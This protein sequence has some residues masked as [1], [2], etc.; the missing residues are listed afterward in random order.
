MRSLLM[1]LLAVLASAAIVDR[2]AV[3][4]GRQVITELQ[5]DEELR[6]TAFLNRQSVIRDINSRKAA[7]NRLIEQLLIESEM[8]V[9]RYPLPGEEDVN[10]YFDQIRSG[11]RAAADFSAALERYGLT[12]KV[13]KDHLALQLTT[14]RFI[15][16]RF[17]PEIDVSE[18]EIQSAYER[19]TADL[20]AQH[21]E[22]APSL[23]AS[24]DSIRKALLEER[25]DRAL[26]AW[27]EQRRKR[28]NV[29]YQ[30]PTLKPE[31]H[32]E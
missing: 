3:I 22:A 1:P 9:S 23:D 6:V 13:L 28:A 14:L 12:E 10:Q 29:E 17:Q 24:R 4:V 31:T 20:R 27:L 2:I 15:E 5:L 26:D 18:A 11:F 32:G 25:V 21:S 8:E 19:E 7:A 30:D 16:F